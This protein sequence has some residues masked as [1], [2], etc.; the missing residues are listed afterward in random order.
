MIE[1]LIRA[2][3]DAP[4]ARARA[5]LITS[6]AEQTGAPKQRIYRHLRTA[7]W[8]S[9]KRRRSD[10]GVTRVPEQSLHL[11][12]AA[13]AKERTSLPE[14]RRSLESEGVYFG[15]VSDAQLARILRE[16]GLGPRVQRRKRTNHESRR[17]THET[18]KPRWIPARETA[19]VA[20][21]EIRGMVYVGCAPIVGGEP[22]RA[23]ID[24]SLSVALIGDNLQAEGMNYWPSYATMDP[25][26]RATYLA[27]LMGGRSNPAYHERY[28]R[29]Y[30]CGLERRFFVDDPDPG[31][32][33]A[34]IAEVE[35]LQEV[36][37]SG[38]PLTGAVVVTD[39]SSR[40]ITPRWEAAHDVLTTFIEAARLV[41]LDYR[42][43]AP[44]DERLGDQIP[45]SVRLGI[46][47]MVQNGVPVPPDWMLAWTLA[48]P[49]SLLRSPDIPAFPE[50]KALFEVRFRDR[51]PNGL[52]LERPRPTVSVHYVNRSVKKRIDELPGISHLSAPPYKA[53][54]IAE[55]VT[56]EL[57]R[58]AESET[59]D[60]GEKIALDQE[61]V[62]TI[63]ADTNYVSHVLHAAL[64]GDDD[65]PE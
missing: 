49:K 22:D 33:S 58:A 7:G 44:I 13:L 15:G 63:M 39:D 37:G 14:A 16:R 32:R 50:F 36:Y 35:R 23:F 12:A 56:Q 34:I 45:L 52:R 5:A 4:S 9:G 20:G 53:A 47:R 60:N 21:R 57:A 19:T 24:S 28:V 25:R 6:Y 3:N 27:W 8:S 51:Y 65:S 10:A 11:L 26:S 31:E 46:G 61:R 29:L 41:Q 59:R 42:G 55:S 18:R 64:S 43:P 48:H 40:G 38:L 1:W 17:S 30:L 54:L 2:L 62:A